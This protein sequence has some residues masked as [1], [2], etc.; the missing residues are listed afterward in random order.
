M[1][2]S[3]QELVKITQKNR[4]LFSHCIPDTFKETLFQ[5]GMNAI[6]ILTGDHHGCAA[7]VSTLENGNIRI[8]SLYVE[9]EYRRSGMGRRIIRA[10][11]SFTEK[12]GQGERHLLIRYPCPKMREMEI[13]LLGCGFQ[14]EEE[15]NQIYYVPVRDTGDLDLLQKEL[16]IPKGQIIAM[17]EMTREQKLHWLH[18]FGNDLPE[19]FSPKNAGGTL[20]EEHTFLYRKDGVEESFV[21]CTHLGDDS[22]YLAALYSEPKAVKALPCLLKAVLS[23]LLLKYED[24]ILCFAASTDSGKRLAEHL[25][26]GHEA[27]IRIE[28][29]RTAVWRGEEQSRKIEYDPF[30]EMD[31]IPRLNSLSLVL[32]DMGIVH[33]VRYPEADTYPG[34]LADIEGKT[35]G[36]SYDLASSV[37]EER[38]VLNLL[39]VPS[40]KEKEFFDLALACQRFNLS[41]PFGSAILD[42]DRGQVLLRCVTPEFGGVIDR[43]T[44]TM[45]IHLF[46]DSIRQ[47]ESQADFA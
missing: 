2:H 45:V 19:A 9:P 46:T 26:R 4:Q 43:E 17:K 22:I 5:K 15:G 27:K 30:G 3:Q 20:L 41:S 31:L 18:R 10:L 35:I 11:Q 6:G 21:I 1:N 23:S 47:F 14:I 39:Y 44:L 34:I 16:P 28:T 33:S 37:E 13:F 29:M 36:I 24:K 42:K 7:A 8:L 12:M 25:C 32:G 40:D 38:F